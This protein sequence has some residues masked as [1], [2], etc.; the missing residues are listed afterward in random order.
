[1]VLAHDTEARSLKT[2]LGLGLGDWDHVEPFHDS[3]SVFS[4]PPEVA[5]V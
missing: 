3:M 2:E 4:F 5:A 1:V